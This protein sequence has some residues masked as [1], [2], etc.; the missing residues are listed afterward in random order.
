MTSDG[1]SGGRLV[2]FG[3]TTEGRLL[4]EW[5]SAHGVPA[6]YCA[7]TELGALSLPGVETR[8]GRLD[9]RGMTALL[10]SEK[11]A[12]VFDAT[13]PYA[14]DASAGIAEAASIMG[15][16]IRLLRV[17][18]EPGD[19]SRCRVFRNEDELLQ[20]LAGTEGVIFAAVGLKTA[21][22]FTRL[23]GFE[24]RVYVRLL[25]SVEGLRTCLELGFPAPRLI[26]M[27]GPFSRDLNR[28]MFAATHAAIL[29]TKDSGSAGGFAEKVEAA[30]DLGMETVL[31]SR[32][33]ELAA[34]TVSLAGAIEA[35]E[36]LWGTGHGR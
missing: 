23:P 26:L 6:L 15:A 22:L 25:P 32:P 33:A 31:I 8:I 4:A 11:P 14:A 3:G 35:A 7:A 9:A 19:T 20:H 36:E 2:I 12:L 28:A 18:R 5:C 13:H 16:G 10:C 1:L 29:V 27:Y 17:V 24:T 34:E 30:T 21:P